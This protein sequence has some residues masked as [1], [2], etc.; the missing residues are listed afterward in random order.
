MKRISYVFMALSALVV[1]LDACSPVVTRP[2][3]DRFR[4]S[5]VQNDALKRFDL[6]LS[7][8]D[9]RSLCISVESWPD[10]TGTFTVENSEVVLR[11]NGEVI[12]S[13][14]P[15]V[16]AYCP[17]GCGYH[18]IDPEGELRGFITYKSFGDP[19][20]IAASAEK[21]LTFDVYPIYCPSGKQGSGSD[22]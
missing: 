17:G 7:S 10:S 19:A 13:K 14:S 3:E 4:L 21:K 6:T 22:F 11:L 16:S 1:V 2:T 8:N 20:K 18:T 12:Q 5:I 15:L 9:Q